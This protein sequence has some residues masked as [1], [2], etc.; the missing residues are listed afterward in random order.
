MAF[1]CKLCQ[2]TYS[3]RKQVLAHERTKHRNNK[4]IPHLHLLLQPSFEQLT[5]YQD[6]FIILIK[7]RLGFN[8]HFSKR[9]LIN[10]FPENI[11][12]H[13]FQSEPSFR[14]NSALK[15]YSC[16][17]KGVEGESRLKQILN[18]KHWSYQQDP[19]T[20]TTGYVLLVN[21]EESYE[22]SFI[23]MQAELIKNNRSFQCGTVT[24]AFITDSGEFTEN[25]ENEQL[26]KNHISTPEITNNNQ[27]IY[28]HILLRSPLQQ[29]ILN[30][31][32]N[33]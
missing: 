9:L 12:V 32:N 14:Y 29:L 10:V 2:K 4:I 19:K 21:Y 30:Q 27:L 13:L 1:I 15:K 20:K 16:T 24:C 3:L 23:W 25:K 7:K 5:T 33:K 18:Y 31:Q 28:R 17:F 8:K 22:V 6:A 26:F 11:F